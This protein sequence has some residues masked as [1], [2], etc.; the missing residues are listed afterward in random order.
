MLASQAW[1]GEVV[2]GRPSGAHISA[3]VRG[4]DFHLPTEGLIDTE[5][6]AARLDKE[7]KRLTDELTKIEA[8]LANPMFAERAK[9]EVVAR[10]REQADELRSALEKARERQ[11]VFGG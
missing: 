8:R 11:S 2:H 7:V 3:T 6:E 5:K 1:V 10:E 9:P 4:V